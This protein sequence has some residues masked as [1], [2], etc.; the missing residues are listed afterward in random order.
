[1]RSNKSHPIVIA[2][3]LI[4]WCVVLPLAVTWLYVWRLG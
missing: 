1:M 2:I 3:T 4:W